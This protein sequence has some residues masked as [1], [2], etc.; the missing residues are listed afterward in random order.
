MLGR[1][2]WKRSAV[3]SEDVLVMV[4]Y[5]AQYDDIPSLSAV[6][7]DNIRQESAVDKRKKSWKQTVAA[8]E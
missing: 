3:R 8:V 1:W 5:S 4:L 7:Y 6:R 2:E